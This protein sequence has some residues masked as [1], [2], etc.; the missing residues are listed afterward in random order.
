MH[1]F[2]KSGASVPAVLL[3]AVAL[4][5]CGSSGS[6]GGSSTGSAAASST[7]HATP[8]AAAS[9]PS[10]APAPSTPAASAAAAGSGVPASCAA[11]PLS[12]MAPYVG[13]KVRL[14]LALPAAPGSVSCEFVSDA[15]H[16]VVLTMGGGG[17]PATFAALKQISAL[18]G[19][20]VT[21]A[22]G[23]GVDAFRISSGSKPGGMAVLTSTGLTI[24][25]TSRDTFAQD[26]SLIRQLLA[27]Y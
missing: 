6:S 18:G 19:R 3:A 12:L 5:G 22:P 11:I 24:S 17:T 23:L 25:L 7:S 9:T 1:P 16:M 13:P 10:T 27:R 20:T 14:G 15:M 21:A 26:E 2:T 4:V 8:S